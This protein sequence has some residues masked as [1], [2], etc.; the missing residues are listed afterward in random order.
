MYVTLNVSYIECTSHKMYV[1]LNARH[2]STPRMKTSLLILALSVPEFHC[3][4]SRHR[5]CYVG[6]SPYHDDW[7]EGDLV[8][9]ESECGVDH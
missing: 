3:W 2:V 7:D 4:C 5:G 8:T 6:S 1:A 9:L